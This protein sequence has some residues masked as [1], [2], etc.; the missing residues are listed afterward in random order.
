MSVICDVNILVRMLHVLFILHFGLCFFVLVFNSLDLC[1]VVVNERN[2]TV[3]QRDIHCVQCEVN[4]S[5][6][7]TSSVLLCF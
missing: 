6:G 2:E 3:L 7:T 4:K 1:N 5:L